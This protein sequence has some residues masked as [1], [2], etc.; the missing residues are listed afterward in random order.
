M[1]P[2]KQTNV[3][4]PDVTRDQITAIAE[5]AG[6]SDGQVIA[7]AVDRLYVAMFGEGFGPVIFE[8]PSERGKGT[9][10]PAPDDT[11]QVAIEDFLN[12]LKGQ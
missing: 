1:A 9:G 3:R 12:R 11:V 4:L 2:K 5:K 8:S 6:M 10:E 7:M